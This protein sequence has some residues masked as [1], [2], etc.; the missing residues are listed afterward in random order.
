[1]CIF[2][3][4]QQPPLCWHLHLILHT[5][6]LWTKWLLIGTAS[7]G[8]GGRKLNKWSNKRERNIKRDLA[9]VKEGPASF[10]WIISIILIIWWIMHYVVVFYDISTGILCIFTKNSSDRRPVEMRYPTH[11]YDFADFPLALKSLHHSYFQ[12]FFW[13]KSLFFFLAVNTSFPLFCFTVPPTC[14]M[15]LDGMLVS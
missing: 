4:S 7:Q 14:G 13:A 11:G 6:L 3:A 15:A 5:C 1:M 2:S 8:T 12:F 10:W 9:R